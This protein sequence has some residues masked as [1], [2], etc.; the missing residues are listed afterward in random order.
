LPNRKL[1]ITNDDPLATSGVNKGETF[2]LGKD[3]FVACA[4]K[5]KARGHNDGSPVERHV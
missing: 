3:E 2:L 4:V 5:R 1:H